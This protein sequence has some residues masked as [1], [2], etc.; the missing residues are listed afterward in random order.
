MTDQERKA[1][2]EQRTREIG[3]THELDI[4]INVSKGGVCEGRMPIGE[5]HMNTRGF[6]HGGSLYA[7]ADTVAVHALIYEHGEFVTISSSFDF[8]NAG[9]A[10][11]VMTCRARVISRQD[12][13]A[14]VRADIS[15]ENGVLIC[16][17]TFYF[18]SVEKDG[19]RHES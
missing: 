12:R 10:G 7:L 14:V 16:T 17:G 1:A 11:S 5:N 8:L 4:E 13:V 2:M 19:G 3:L 15:D 6:V 9:L 18:L